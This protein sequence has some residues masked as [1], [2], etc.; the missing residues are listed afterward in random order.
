MRNQLGKLTHECE[1]G[2]SHGIDGGNL[3][4]QIGQPHELGIVRHVHTPYRI[5]YQLTTDRHLITDGLL[6]IM[7][8]GTADVEVLV[9]GIVQIQTQ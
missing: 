2:G 6:A 5:V 7:H 1:A 4:E 8:D 9:E 3:V